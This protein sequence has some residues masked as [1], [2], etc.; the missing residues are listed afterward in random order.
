MVIALHAKSPSGNLAKFLPLDA[1]FISLGGR[2][3]VFALSSSSP[4]SVPLCFH[5]G[6]STFSIS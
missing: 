2:I 5:L 1:S 6:R 4:G 3:P